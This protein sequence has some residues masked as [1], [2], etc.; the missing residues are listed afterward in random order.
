MTP[1][2]KTA[3]WEERFFQQFSRTLAE[4]KGYLA[5]KEYASA[6][7]F[8]VFEPYKIEE[9][10]RTELATARA[11]ERMRIRQEVGMLN[12][13]YFCKSEEGFDG[14]VQYIPKHEALNQ[15]DPIHQIDKHGNITALPMGEDDT[16]V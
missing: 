15:C 12:G 2:P 9:F 16:G 1:S 4:V 5:A 8:P 14:T 6:F 7:G 3:T 11:E 13:V 10:I